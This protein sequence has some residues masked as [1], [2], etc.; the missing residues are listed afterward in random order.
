MQTTPL[1]NNYRPTGLLQGPQGPPGPSGPPGPPGVV[2]GL[3][4]AT[5]C[6][7]LGATG[8]VYRDPYGY[9]TLIWNHVN[10]T[11]YY[12]VLQTNF[13]GSSSVQAAVLIQNAPA[14]LLNQV[15]TADP[16]AKYFYQ[17]VQ[18]NATV[19]LYTIAA[20]D[21]HTARITLVGGETV[22]PLFEFTVMRTQTHLVSSGRRYE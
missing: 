20:P 7:P 11:L 1:Q 9:Y 6:Q 3:M 14:L 17:A 22:S 12:S 2:S 15:G 19:A 18:K 8:V 21:L 4:V 16:S 10:Y 5:I 13:Y